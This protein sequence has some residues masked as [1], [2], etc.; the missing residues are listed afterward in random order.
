MIQNRAQNRIPPNFYRVGFY[1]EGFG[2][3]NGKEFIYREPPSLRLADFTTNLV[4][5][6]LMLART[7]AS[8]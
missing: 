4:V 1:G 7:R 6:T 5:R 2:D 8:N 3:D